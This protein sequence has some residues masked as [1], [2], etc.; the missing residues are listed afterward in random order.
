MSQIL[1]EINLKRVENLKLFENNFEPN[2]FCT[3]H[4]LNSKQ[5]IEFLSIKSSNWQD[6]KNL[7]KY[8]EWKLLF[9]SNIIYENSSPEFNENL[10]FELKNFNFHFLIFQIWDYDSIELN[11]ERL[12]LF[13]YNFFEIE[14]EISISLKEQRGAPESITMDLDEL[15]DENSILIFDFQIKKDFKFLSFSKNL[16]ENLNLENF[17][18]LVFKTSIDE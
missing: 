11:T 10:K 9:V 16:Q 2:S 7:S 17:F 4:L 8:F 12:S 13:I 15:N 14:K 1:I 18:D 5:L 6:M 3:I